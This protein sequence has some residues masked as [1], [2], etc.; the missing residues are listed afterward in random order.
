MASSFQE[1]QTYKRLCQENASFIEFSKKNSSD[2]ENTTNLRELLKENE[3]LPLPCCEVLSM[4]YQ[5][6]KVFADIQKEEIIYKS[7][8]IQANNRYALNIGNWYL[9]GK[10]LRTDNFHPK[11]SILI[12]NK[13]E[14]DKAFKYICEKKL[15]SAEMRNKAEILEKN[16]LF[17]VAV[18]FYRLLKGEFAK[19]KKLLKTVFV[20]KNE[21]NLDLKEI[22]NNMM[23]FETSLKDCIISIQKM[24]KNYIF[25]IFLDSKPNSLYPILKDYT[26]TIHKFLMNLTREK[27][28]DTNTFIKINIILGH[29]TV[30]LKKILSLPISYENFNREIFIWIDEI[31]QENKKYEEFYENYYGMVYIYLMDQPKDL[32]KED[33]K[34]LETL[35]QDYDLK[36]VVSLRQIETFAS[37]YLFDK[38]DYRVIENYKMVLS[39]LKNYDKNLKEF[40]FC[41]E[42]MNKIFVG[43]K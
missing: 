40:T 14:I 22:I 23:N 38:S 39:P 13:E 4:I 18:L 5:I 20:E 30:F 10:I 37:T 32:K 16:L 29:L 24:Y 31:E 1:Y 35:L 11:I 19:D 7:E 2:F 15:D 34:S 25:S 21:M 6:L 42:K 27:G 28:L 9:K 41:L 12:Y 17:D 43:T 8:S 36:N 26:F 33:L 3:S